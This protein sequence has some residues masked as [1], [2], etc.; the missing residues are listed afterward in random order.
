MLAPANRR[1]VAAPLPATE[2]VGAPAD[3][4]ALK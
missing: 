1:L 4:I 3:P 2:A